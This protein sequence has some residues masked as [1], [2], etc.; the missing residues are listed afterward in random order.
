[1]TLES[2]IEDGD[3]IPEDSMTYSRRLRETQIT[4]TV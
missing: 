2:M 3:P 1:M 4:I